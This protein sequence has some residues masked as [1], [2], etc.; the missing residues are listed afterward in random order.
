MYPKILYGKEDQMFLCS[1]SKNGNR[2][3]FTLIELLVVVAIIAVLVAL[4]LP[5]LKSAREHAKKT[6]CLANLNSFGKAF[7][8]YAN[9]NWGFTPPRM[10]YEEHGWAVTSWKCLLAPYMGVSPADLWPWGPP[11]GEWK[12]SL[13]VMKCPGNLIPRWTVEHYY[14]LNMWGLT[15]WGTMGWSIKLDSIR[16]HNILVSELDNNDFWQYTC[17]DF[18][19]PS[20]PAIGPPHANGYDFLFADGHCGWQKNSTWSQ[21]MNFDPD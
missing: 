14:G 2:K 13:L 6:Q 10:V 20:D 21:W 3:S 9:D 11:R 15:K 7:Q 17:C 19:Y 18:A 16:L 5:A 1:K 4:L 8:Y 12:G